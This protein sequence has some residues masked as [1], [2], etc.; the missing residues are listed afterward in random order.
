MLES[1]LTLIFIITCTAEF[2]AR[3]FAIDV[4]PFIAAGG[5]ATPGAIHQLNVVKQ[6]N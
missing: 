4:S 3:M 1:M 2:T 6:I 5:V